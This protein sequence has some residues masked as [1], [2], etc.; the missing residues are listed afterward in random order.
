MNILFNTTSSFSINVQIIEN[1]ISN[2]KPSKS[3]LIVESAEDL[4][5]NAEENNLLKF[6]EKF[7]TEFIDRTPFMQTFIDDEILNACKPIDAELL[8]KMSKYEAVIFSQLQRIDCK[9]RDFYLM[10]ERYISILK[11]W[12]N[13]LEENSI[14]YFVA[15]N[16]PHE[17]FDYIIYCLCKIKGIKTLFSYQSPI[18]S[19]IY[20]LQD[21]EEGCL[22]LEQK[23]KEY[24]LKYKDVGLEEI[25][26]DETSKEVINKYF[27]K[28]DTTPFYMKK[29]KKNIKF[30]IN[31]FKY[32][33]KK[34]FLN[35]K[36]GVFIKN[37]KFKINKNSKLRR[38]YKKIIKFYNKLAIK[39]I[40][41]DGKTEKF[42]YLPLHYQ[43]ECTSNPLGSR[44]ENQEFM[45]Q[46]I[47]AA[48]PEGYYLYVKEH[49]KQD[50][51]IYR[52]KKFFNRINKL[53][54]VR[55]VATNVKTE[56]LT[57]HCVATAT[58]TG[59][60]AWES[61][62]NLKPV[63]LFGNFCYQYSK[64]VFKIKANQDLKDAIQNI[65]GGNCLT[66]K[67]VILFVKALSDCSKEGYVDEYYKSLIRVSFEQAVEN[68]SEGF[69][70]V[71][72]R[73][74]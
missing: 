29:E 59:T 14:D 39:N 47:S 22:G 13:F 48:L 9:F 38:P 2:I 33:V 8:N 73:N 10:Y 63:L 19:Q 16:C 34:V 50:S 30:F 57:E 55:L 64:G 23:V 61:I 51:N 3:Y 11:F 52:S 49:P 66:K 26:L 72:K 62:F 24:E 68:I 53:K 15:N 20:F 40:V 44:Y 25:P 74:M 41:N 70:E 36:N 31:K 65:V 56:I 35:I 5:K 4:H 1:I 71:I 60:A 21:I 69:I 18:T 46:M 54:N 6:K 27:S 58:L 43:P 67:D 42:I 17:G 28:E 7:N 12:N 45:I 37:I 32:F